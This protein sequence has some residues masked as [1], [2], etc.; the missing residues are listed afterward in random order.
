MPRGSLGLAA[1]FRLPAVLLARVFPLGG[2]Q[3]VWWPACVDSLGRAA[4]DQ[5][6][7]QLNSIACAGSP[8]GSYYTAFSDQTFGPKPWK[9][10]YGPRGKGV[11]FAGSSRQ[12]ICRGLMCPHS[13]K[14]RDGP[15]WLCNSG[16]G[17]VGVLEVAS[18]ASEVGN[19]YHA[20]ATVPGFTRGLAFAGPY[21]F[22]GLS[23]GFR[24]TE[25]GRGRVVRVARGVPDL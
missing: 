24:H 4:F 8:E 11:V 18:E 15:L 20:V 21:G 1:G 22:V 17:E 7:L 9:E 12:V 13:A 23:R 5:N 2:W 19:R 3:R 16:Y 10:G 14:L 6:Y 25:R